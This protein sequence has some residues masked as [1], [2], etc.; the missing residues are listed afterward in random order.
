MAFF[1]V[2]IYQKLRLSGTKEKH[3]GL[4]MTG[5]II[6]F[7]VF[8]ICDC[9]IIFR[10]TEEGYKLYIVMSS[11]LLVNSMLILSQ[12]DISRRII[13]NRYLAGLLVLRTVFF[14]FSLK[15]T[16]MAVYQIIDASAGLAAGFLITLLMS[17]L[18]KNGLG[19]GDVK[20]FAVMG[21]FAGL[22][23]ILDILLYTCMFCFCFS[24]VCLVLK[25]C[26][27][28]SSIP[29]APFA[30]LGTVFYFAFMI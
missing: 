23:G 20:M 13:P 5:K 15:N 12:T 29:M 24:V 28:K 17:M 22:S 2:F 26:S 21:Y 11:V 30:F 7:T 6:L 27:L 14:C 18:S 1:F 19:A 25:K 10:M 16:G 9:M 8:L 3:A 4:K